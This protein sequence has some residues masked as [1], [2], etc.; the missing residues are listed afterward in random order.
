MPHLILAADGLL[1]DD[2]DDGDLHL[3]GHVSGFLAGLISHDIRRV[4][5][6]L[7]IT[8]SQT[9][10]CGLAVPIWRICKG[11]DDGINIL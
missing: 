6:P 9:T 5:Q 1:E 8:K 7:D 11:S 3:K 4:E 10:C 2:Q